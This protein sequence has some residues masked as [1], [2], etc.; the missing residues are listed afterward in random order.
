MQQFDACNTLRSLCKHHSSLL[1]QQG[2]AQLSNIV[3]YLLKL[4]ESLRSSL[5]K[6][7]LM[8]INDMIVNL[9]RCMEPYLEQLIKILLKKASLD[10]NSFISEEADRALITMCTYCQDARVLRALL[11]ATN[12][13]NHKSNLV[14]QRICKCFETVRFEFHYSLF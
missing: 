4:A 13:G 3:T 14:R 6:I 2:V 9:K 10:T 7:S 11:T 5:S 1:L 8:T 12:G